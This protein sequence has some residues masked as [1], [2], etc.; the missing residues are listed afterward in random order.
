M[1][2]VQQTAITQKDIEKGL[3]YDEYR[4]LVNDLLKKGKTTGDQP[5]RGMVKFTQL[6]E[7]RMKRVDK[8]VY[9][10]PELEKEIK[11]LFGKWYWVVLTE[12]WCGDAAHSL[13]VIN[14][15][16]QANPNIELS[17]L[18]RD[19]NLH[20]MDAYLTN[21]SRSIPKLIVLNTD[22]LEEKGTWGPKPK[23]AKNLHL[24][25]KKNDSI[26]HKENSRQVQK[27]YN[28]DKSQTL[29]K[30]FIQ[31]IRQWKHRTVGEESV[32]WA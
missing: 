8:T 30:E 9:L 13:P 3:S 29:Q 10:Q 17:I 21:G 20:I 32:K 16:A 6:N 7:A 31:K 2:Q 23:P 18:L 14:K 24:R 4:K 27:W 11:N 28:Q 22:T 1:K 19:E 25:Y 12:G 5:S 26:S 15:M